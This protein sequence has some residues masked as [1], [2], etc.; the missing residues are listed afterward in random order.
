M[1]GRL[2]T[3]YWR[4][5]TKFQQKEKAQTLEKLLLR[6]VEE[7]TNPGEKSIYFR[8]FVNLATSEESIAKMESLWSKNENIAGLPLFE[9]DYTLLAYELAVRDVKNSKRI[10][11]EQLPT[12]PPQHHRLP[13]KPHSHLLAGAAGAI[14]YRCARVIAF[15]QFVSVR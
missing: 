13:R 4:L 5:L 6:L 12:T 14:T 11:N 8:A 3:I 15:D 10:L 1:V 2:T 9:R 7:K